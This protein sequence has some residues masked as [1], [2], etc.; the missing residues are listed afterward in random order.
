MGRIE[1]NDRTG[2]VG[3]GADLTHRVRKEVEAAADRNH[4]RP[5][6]QRHIPQ[7]RHV[8]RVVV[9]ENRREMNVEA[10]AAGAAAEVMGHVAAD[11]R[12]RGDNAVARLS[13]GHE[14][15][16]IGNGAGR[17]PDFR[18]A[19]AEDFGGEFGGDHFDTFDAFEAHL[20]LAA[21]ISER[22]PGPEAGGESPLSPR[23]HDVRRRIEVDAVVLVDRAVERDRVV[24]RS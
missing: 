17:N 10:V 18:V 5:Q 6:L 21:W 11:A 19:R 1:K 20:I 24:D 2:L 15:V 22:R 14:G 16:E 7:R 9:G 8:D 12:R 3:N 13:S 4:L 23:I